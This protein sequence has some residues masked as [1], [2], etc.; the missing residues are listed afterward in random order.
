[1]SKAIAWYDDNAEMAVARY[2]EAPFEAVHG[3]LIDLLPPRP[4][5]ILDVGAGGGRD[6]A[7]LDARGYEV[8]A[9]EP[10][11]SMRSLATRLHPEASIQW[12][13]D[14]LPELGVVGPSGLS[15]HV[16][17][18]SAV[19]IHIPAHERSRAFRRLMELLKPGGMLAMTLRDGPLDKER[20]IHPV[21]LVE[22]ETLARTHGASVETVESRNGWSQ[23]RE[24]VE[25]S[26]IT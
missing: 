9:V 11:A 14:R 24:S 20:D 8:V 5:L 7:W 26:G 6:A 4:A 21:S 17:L 25:S 10:S 18:L 15:F 2:E 12:F 3:W 16:I 22:V 1:M 13:D 19:W 23:T